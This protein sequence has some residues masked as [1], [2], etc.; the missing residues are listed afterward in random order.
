M[1]PADPPR[2]VSSSVVGDGGSGSGGAGTG[3]PGATP[4]PPAAPVQVIRRGPGFL[5]LLLGGLLAGAIGYAFAFWAMGQGDDSALTD[6]LAVIEERLDQSGAPDLTPLET[7]IAQAREEARA[8]DATVAAQVEGRLAEGEG[9]LAQ[10][11]DALETQLAE[12]APLVE[13][14]GTLERRPLSDGTLAPGGVQ[15]YEA[16]V[17]ELRNALDAQA[18]ESRA[19][20]DDALAEIAEARAALDAGLTDAASRTDAAAADLTA[21]VDGTLT[22]LEARMDTRMA[23]LTERLE[24]ARA[25]ATSRVDAA[26]EELEARRAEAEAAAARAARAVDAREELTAVIRA[27]DTGAPFASE[28]AALGEALQAPLPDALV[29]SAMDGVPTRGDLAAAFPDAA[30]AALTAARQAGATPDAGGLGGVL[31]SQFG[32]RSTAPREGDDPDAILSRAQAEVDA[33]RIDAALAELS[34]L[35]ESAQAPL[36]DWTAAARTRV[37]AIAALDALTDTLNEG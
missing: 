34:A 9:A 28:V 20:L 4:P 31:R 2:T 29:R 25:D 1:P 13:R 3:D 17:A 16:Q 22:D 6:R 7:A 11:F 15:A 30:R 27:V 10:R 21:R 12:L 8:G 24:T 33:G 14:V 18:T 5:P 32:V 19:R 23:E 26:L 37:D 36:A 35:P